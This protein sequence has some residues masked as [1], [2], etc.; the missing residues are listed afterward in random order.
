MKVFSLVDLCADRA[1]IIHITDVG[2]MWLGEK[3]DPHERLLAKGAAKLV[4]FEP[5]QAECDKLNKMH[6]G[7]RLYLPY[8]IGD[9]TLRTFHLCNTVM[10]SSLYEPYSELLDKFQNLENLTQVVERHPVQTRRLDDIDEVADTDYLKVDVQGAEWDVFQG[11]KRLLRNALVVHTEVEFVPLYREQPLFAEVDRALRESG[12]LLHNISGTA[13]RMF[14]PLVNHD[15]L[16]AHGSQ[17]LWADVV[18]IRNF[19][20]LD[21][22]LPTQ[23]LKLAIILHEVYAS[24][25]TCAFVLQAYDRK[26]GDGLLDAYY[27][28]LLAK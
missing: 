11:A 5:V 6:A 14:K 9:G 7:R 28:Q 10:T 16:N 27:K 12:F 15:D 26:T 1:P 13:S 20:H 25:D 17:L 3:E 4:G 2:A 22:L 21:Q 23:L 8:A 24:L 19:M 18:Y